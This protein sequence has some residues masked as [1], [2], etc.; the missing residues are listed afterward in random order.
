LAGQIGNRASSYATSTSVTGTVRY[1]RIG[2]I[3]NASAN[4][5]TMYI[6]DISIWDARPTE[7][8]EIYNQA[9]TTYTQGVPAIV[10]VA[11]TTG[12]TITKVETSTNNATWT[13]ISTAGG[14]RLP[15]GFVLM[16]KPPRPN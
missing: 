2:M 13:D 16:F 8:D 10:D 6:H 14:F 9:G 12:K 1:V 4:I 5:G 3:N 11:A 15:P 7:L